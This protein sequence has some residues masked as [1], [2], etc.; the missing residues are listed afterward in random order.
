MR[1]ISFIIVLILTTTSF[2]YAYILKSYVI[3]NGGVAKMTSNGYIMGGS[4]SQSF[5]GKLENSNYT[6][7]IG[8]WD[9]PYAPYGIEETDKAIGLGQP[10][11]FSLNQNFPNP[12]LSKTT[13]KYAIPKTCKVELK[14]YDVT[15][16]KVT[17]LVDENQK[18]GYYKV[19][20]RIRNVSEKQLANGI[21]FYRLKAGDFVST[22]KM[23]IV[24]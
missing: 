14:L 12:V 23:V 10:M 16:R 22:K 21:Y 8:Y 5:I 13:I 7:Y 20:W 3:D 18:P 19:N 1:K 17:V 2:T 15:G 6:A 24:R 11:V 9:K 4:V